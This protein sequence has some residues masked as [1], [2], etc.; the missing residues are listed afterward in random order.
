MW[1]KGGE[2]EGERGRKVSQKEECQRQ[3][4]ESQDCSAAAGQVNSLSFRLVEGHRRKDGSRVSK[5]MIK[6]SV[7]RN[8]SWM[9]MGNTSFV[10]VI[11]E[12]RKASR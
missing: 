4:E 7:A 8:R 1:S 10:D 12:N 9:P 2:G 11:R 5:R 6:L 3:R